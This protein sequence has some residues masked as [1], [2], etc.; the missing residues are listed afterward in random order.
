[1]LRRALL[2]LPVLLT[3]SPCRAETE[4]EKANREKILLVGNAADPRS[5][6]P[7]V[8]TGVVEDNVI[9]SL[10]EG[11]VADDESSDTASPPGAASSW[12]HNPE[13]TEWTFHLRPEGKWSDGTPLTAADFLFAYQRILHPDLA[14][15][16][17]EMLF[18]IK[19][20]ERFNKG[21]VKDFKEVGVAAPDDFTLKLTLREP[22]PFLPLLVRHYTWFPLPR[23]VVLKHGG[24]TERGNPWSTAENFIGNGP[25]TLKEWKPKEY[26][27]VVKNPL[28]RDAAKVKLNGLRF[29]PSADSSVESR[30]FLAGKLHLTW[31]LPPR[32][33]DQ[34]RA[35]NPQYLRQ[36]P[37]FCT[38][39]I[40]VNTTRP[41]LD[42]PKLRQALS[43]AIDRQSLCDDFV[44]GN[45]PAGT[46][47][48]D[49]GDYHPE[50]LTGF[51]PERAKTLLAEAGYPGGA[52]LPTFKLL[53][54]NSV[55]RDT[56]E[57]IAGMWRKTLGIGVE[58]RPEEFGEYVRAQYKLDYDLAL[59]GW[60]GDYMDPSTFL[61]L[62]MKDNG[63]NNTGWSSAEYDKL[64]GEAAR[65]AD[66]AQRLATFKKAERLL[67]EELPVLPVSYRGRNYLQ[68]PEV[69]GWH[70]LLL[71]NHPWQA[72]SLEP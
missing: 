67:M 46:I 9:R 43:L 1:M 71:D 39:L 23:H 68:R 61:T 29:I 27:E 41:K 25:F 44:K 38:D 22:V 47:N 53:V 2:L 13:L 11:L 50:Q 18:F 42:N 19:N 26:L 24:M 52:G 58:L 17:C 45:R 48:P 5:L 35:N 32:L 65:Q 28:Y 72:V 10:M 14:A 64:L 16:Y 69:K 7:Q 33:V 62:W 12:E 30:A 66:P 15:P 55:P 3:L 21:E 4:V 56:T 36:E 31:Q 57:A 54:T 60:I 49:Q 34:F 6:D 63:N 8:V 40:R 51:D 70:P 37:Y 20:A 59:A